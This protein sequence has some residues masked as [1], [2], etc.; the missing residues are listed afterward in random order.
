MLILTRK[1]GESIQI[2]DEITVT[3]IGVQGMQVRLGINAPK[4]VAVDREEIAVRKAAGSPKP[5]PV[6]A[7]DEPLY[8]NRTEAEW[9]ELLA[10]EKAAGQSEGASHANA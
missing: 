1:V 8:A 10:Q 7:D 5:A 4:N 6:P 9:R 2:G 3:V